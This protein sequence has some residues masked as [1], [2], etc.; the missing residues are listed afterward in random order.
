MYF[1][2]LR[3][4]QFEIDALLEVPASVY[5]NTLPILEPINVSHPKLYVSLTNNG[6]PFILVTNPFYPRTGT[7]SN[8]DVQNIIDGE[9]AAHTSLVLGFL[10][11]QRFDIND[12]NVFL[13]SNPNREKAIIF[14]YNPAQT[15]LTLIQTSIG[16]HPVEYIIFDEGKTTNR[17]HNF[18][19]SHPQRV[20]LTDGFQRQ[21]R[22][23][24]YPLSSTFDSIYNTW[25]TDGWFGIGD[26]LSIG[27]F[28]R[29]GG[30]Q[31]Y[32]VTLHVTIHTPS[33]LVMHHFSSTSYPSTGGF[34][35]LKFSE[36]NQS[37]VSSSH[38]I[39]ITSNGLTLYR[40]WHANSH[41]P[42]LGAAKKASMMH[43]IELMSG[44]I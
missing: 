9:L 2:Y 10:I 17:T 23:A 36:A 25:R 27:D 1:P 26:Y 40:N 28:F 43:H 37:L 44:I 31:A 39:P 16:T 38:I 14:R 21:E 20:L 42:S 7:L 34:T 33:S 13:T 5:Q 29:S 30:G 35:A 22:N 18:F 24:D 3:G 41:N 4:K 19:N 32:V 6:I 15:D 11:D 8:N 12:L